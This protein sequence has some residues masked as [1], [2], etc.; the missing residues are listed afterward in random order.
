LAQEAGPTP[1]DATPENS[2]P[3]EANV[4]VALGAKGWAFLDS[5]KP[6]PPDWVLGTFDNADWP[7]GQ[8]PLGY[9]DPDI[10]TTVSF[11][12]DASGK[13]P[14]TWIR[15]VVQVGADQVQSPQ[16]EGEP[17]KMALVGQL[18][19]DDGA[20]VYLNGKA[21]FRQNVA[22]AETDSNAFAAATTRREREQWKF[23][24][25]PGDFVAGKNIIAVSVHQGGPNSTDLAF[26][27]EL[28]VIAED[29]REAI[30]AVIERRRA[31]VAAAEKLRQRMRARG[32]SIMLPDGYVE[33]R[34]FDGVRM[35][36]RK[37]HQDALAQAR[38]NYG[39]KFQRVYAG[40]TIEKIAAQAGTPLPRLLRLN[41][42][43]GGKVFEA[44]GVVCIQWGYEVVAGQTLE[45]IATRFETTVRD[46]RELN[47]WPR[48]RTPTEGERILVPGQWHYQAPRDEQQGT[49]TL[50]A[51]QPTRAE[52]EREA[53]LNPR[54]RARAIDR[55][56]EVPLPAVPRVD[57][58]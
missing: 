7:R 4:L 14:V 15:R 54:R 32:G 3:E 13:Q 34:W 48:E 26:D 36:S 52:R 18:I 30:E 53:R 11:G 20:V 33:H 46:L 6:P 37:E 10:A 19:C 28:R 35:V 47:E 9:G 58:L 25:A 24:V 16:K 8:A 31:E 40:D 27:L 39:V 55:P 1:E 23:T 17:G 22:E 57:E 56:A 42:E 44:T 45:A 41:R 21:V 38:E 50:F 43:R 29:R 51:V 5:G 49:L 2:A 12:D